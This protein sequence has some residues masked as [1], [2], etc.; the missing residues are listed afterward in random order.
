MDY[1]TKNNYQRYTDSY[2]NFNP[3]LHNDAYCTDMMF[4]CDNGKKP[5]VYYKYF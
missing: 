1:M 2:S 4:G 3:D 5:F